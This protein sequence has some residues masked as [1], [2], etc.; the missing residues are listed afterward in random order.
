MTFISKAKIKHNNKYDYSKVKYVNAR[1]KVIIICKEHGEFSQTPTGHVSGNGCPKCAHEARKQ[2]RLKRYGTTELFKSDYFKSKS[3]NT[4]IERYGVSHPMHSSTIKEHHKNTMLQRYNVPHNWCNGTLYNNKKQTYLKK[5]GVDNPLKSK[6]IRDKIKQTHLERLGVDNP[7]KSKEI[8]NKRDNT[9]LIKYGA[10]YTWSSTKLRTQNIQTTRKKYGVNYPSQYHMA[11]IMHLLEDQ[12]WLYEQYITNNKT[13]E[14][15]AQELNISSTTI[16]SYLHKHEVAIRY[17]YGYSLKSIKWL[18]QIAEQYNIHIQ[19]ALNGGEYRI[20][21]T[22][23]KADG[24]CEETNTIYEFHGDHWHGNPKLFESSVKCHP[25]S[26]LTAHELYNKTLD[27]ENTI[28]S[29]GY[30]LVVM[31]ESDFDDLTD[32]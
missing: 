18:N 16:Q 21:N 23:Y 22:R 14:M 11:D 20:P 31:W 15:I 4:M 24:Y 28:K 6:E 13:S 17:S 8:R 32:C 10:K 2:T 5:Y 30:N 27:K 26:D 25:W 7:F 9:M 19:H 3:T 12:D 1:T 29:R